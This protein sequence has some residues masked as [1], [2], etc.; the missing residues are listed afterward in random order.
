MMC[1]YIMDRTQ[2]YLSPEETSV[3]AELS[4]A[5]GVSRSELIRRAI[6]QVY[7]Q[8]PTQ[9]DWLA[10]LET[11]AGAWQQEPVSGHE[12]AER[13]RQGGLARRLR[14]RDSAGPG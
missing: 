10:I 11:T 9:T 1:I 12:Y 3:L 7:L 4:Q 14:T 5:R 2:I 8:Q 6:Q 13:M